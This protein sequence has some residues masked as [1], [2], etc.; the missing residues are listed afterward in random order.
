MKSAFNRKCFTLQV[1]LPGENSDQLDPK[2]NFGHRVKI[3][4]ERNQKNIM[5]LI[6]KPI[7][8]LSKSNNRNNENIQNENFNPR[9]DS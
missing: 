8:F 1:K 2:T 9:N 5:F 3:K 7:I 6:A 4:S